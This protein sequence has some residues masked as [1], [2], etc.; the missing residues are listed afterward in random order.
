MNPILFLPK[1]LDFYLFNPLTLYSSKFSPFLSTSLSYSFSIPIG[2][3]LKLSD[4]VFLNKIIYSKY[5]KES[6]T[7]HSHIPPP[8]PPSLIILGTWCHRYFSSIFT[9][10]SPPTCIV[11]VGM[12]LS[13]SYASW[14]RD[15]KALALSPSM[16]LKGTVIHLVDCAVT[17]DQFLIKIFNLYEWKI[18]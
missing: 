14:K 13:Q 12:A 18:N 5:A 15:R 1:L 7:C 4:F 6:Q 16:T 17:G 2:L 3:V 9:V 8:P 10:W 11:D